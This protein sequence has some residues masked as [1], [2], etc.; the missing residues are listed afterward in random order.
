MQ[1]CGH[2]AASCQFDTHHTA[3][4]PGITLG[5]VGQLSLSTQP[6]NPISEIV[7]PV[8]QAIQSSPERRCSREIGIEIN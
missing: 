6:I 2:L 4:R 1:A 8:A 7:G 5:V 3:N